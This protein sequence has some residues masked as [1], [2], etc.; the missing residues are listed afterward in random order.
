M[1]AA[2]VRASALVVGAGVAGAAVAWHLV[3][4]GW[5]DVHVVDERGRPGEGTTGRATGGYRAQYASAINVRLS[6]LTR[7]KLATFAEETGGD[8]GYRPCGYLWLATDPDDLAELEAGRQVQLAAG[9]TEAV[10]LTPDEA[11]R[12]NPAIDDDAIVGATYCPTDGFVR[13]LGLLGGYL[14]AATRAGARVH[15]GERVQEVT[16]GADRLVLG[17]ETTTLR[18]APEQV[19]LCGGCWSGPLAG[20]FGHWLPV[21]P[22][23]RQV[24]ATVPQAALPEAMPMTI[25]A[26]DGFHLRVRDGRV[27]LLRPTPGDPLDEWADQVEPAWLDAIRA[28]MDARLPALRA[29]PIDPAASWAGLY[30]MTPDRHAIVGRLPGAP[31]VFVQTGSSGHGVMHA[32]ALGQLL[33]ELM[34]DGRYVTLD[35]TVLRAERFAAGESLPG[36]GLL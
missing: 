34:T 14:D 23:R 17:V 19:V 12:L 1:S 24:A 7:A 31:N 11:R 3:Q 13:P 5:R 21:R 10:A 20:R 6:L 29:V 18:F 8:A 36:S 16:R 26:G 2:P 25:W 15:W 33:A 35:A 28:S 32:P 4:R 27:L 9:L 22:L 30:E